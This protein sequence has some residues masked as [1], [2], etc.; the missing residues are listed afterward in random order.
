MKCVLFNYKVTISPRGM[1]FTANED[2]NQLG[3]WLDSDLI[4]KHCQASR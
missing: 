4:V 2:M 3:A 1:Q